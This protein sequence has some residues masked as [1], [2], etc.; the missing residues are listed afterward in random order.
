MIGS[1]SE[2]DA[3]ARADLEPGSMVDAF[4]IMRIIGARA[5]RAVPRRAAPRRARDCARELSDNAR[6]NEK[7]FGKRPR[8]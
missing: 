5:L 2:A 8:R 6:A 1:P 3:S 7:T 4:K